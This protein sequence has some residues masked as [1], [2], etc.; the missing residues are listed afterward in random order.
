MFSATTDHARIAAAAL[1][2]LPLGLVGTLP[3]EAARRAATVEAIAVTPEEPVL[4]DTRTT[5][6]TARIRATG[7]SSVTVDFGPQDGAKE[8]V[9]AVRLSTSGAVQ[10]WEASL[11]LD[12]GRPT[13]LWDV[14]VNAW[15]GVAGTAVRSE[16]V[17]VRRE[18]R[19][20]RFDAGPEPVRRS[21]RLR[22]EGRITRLDPLTTPD[23]MV[24]YAGARV[25]LYFSDGVQEPR[26]WVHVAN[27]TT[28]SL[29]R[30]TR[31]VYARR[32]GYWRAGL[33]GT[34]DYAPVY[35]WPD[36]VRLTR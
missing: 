6:L 25:R 12:R 35:S 4:Y 33:T 19:F 15:D 17:Y 1:L 13:G 21:G 2:A 32:T 7:A 8:K 34:A 26:R 24:R 14:R 31:T 23:G 18:T 9:D 28:D 16:Q 27:A 11:T 3:A 36:H 5:K 30:F 20:T 29:G 22:L 10:Q